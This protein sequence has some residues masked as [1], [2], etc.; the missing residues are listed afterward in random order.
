MFSANLI[1]LTQT[2]HSIVGS[3]NQSHLVLVCGAAITL[4]FTLLAN[5]LCASY[6]VS[7]ISF[8]SAGAIRCGLLEK[9]RLTIPPLESLQLDRLQQSETMQNGEK[10]HTT[11][12]VREQLGKS[13]WDG[14][15]Q[16]S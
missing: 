13:V 12:V 3:L 10:L 5:S 16:G 4:L 6:Q 2:S 11:V 14:L 9:V 8:C 15:L 1:G 7:L